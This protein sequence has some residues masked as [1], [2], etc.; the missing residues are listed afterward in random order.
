MEESSQLPA[1]AALD[2]VNIPNFHWIG[3]WVGPSTSLDV[4]AKGKI[5]TDERNPHINE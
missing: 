4:V 2:P 3:V 1:P 5:I